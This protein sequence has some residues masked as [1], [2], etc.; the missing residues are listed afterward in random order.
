LEAAATQGGFADDDLRIREKRELDLSTRAIAES[1]K[2]RDPWP[3]LLRGHLLAPQ[4]PPPSSFH[5]LKPRRPQIQVTKITKLQVPETSSDISISGPNLLFFIGLSQICTLPT[6]TL[7]INYFKKISN[8]FP[9]IIFQRSKF[10]EGKYLKFFFLKFSIFETDM[11]SSK[12]IQ[13]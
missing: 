2:R 6:L 4:L 1:L 8:F 13:Q 5:V 12:F 9:Q 7:I 10:C 3:T 11:E